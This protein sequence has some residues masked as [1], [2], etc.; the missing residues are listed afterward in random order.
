[1]GPRQVESPQSL[2]GSWVGV[3]AK[4][5]VGLCVCAHMHVHT[6]IYMRMCAELVEAVAMK[7]C[8]CDGGGGRIGLPLPRQHRP[9]T[10]VHSPS[11]TS[12]PCGN[13]T[14]RQRAPPAKQCPTLPSSQS[15]AA[16]PMGHPF[17]TLL[18][19]WFSLL[20]P[21]P[22]MEERQNSCSCYL[23][24]G[25]PASP[26]C[27]L[28]WLGRWPENLNPEADPLFPSEQIPEWE[29]P[30]DLPK[31]WRQ[32]GYHLSPSRSRAALRVLQAV[33]GSA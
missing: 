29:G 14:L 30:G 26:H 11:A 21:S 1:M 16:L 24:S 22:R 18:A 33:P 32:A 6:H 10:L 4:A 31:D 3:V 7:E 8:E 17:H 25:G 28:P 13:A 19:M 27:L 23:H 9:D 15:L 20:T 5:C 2:A 12:T